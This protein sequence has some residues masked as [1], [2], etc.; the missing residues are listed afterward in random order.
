MFI[1]SSSVTTLFKVTNHWRKHRRVHKSVVGIVYCQTHDTI[2]VSKRDTL[3]TTVLTQFEEYVCVSC[4]TPDQ[5]MQFVQNCCHAV[6]TVDSY[7]H[8]LC[9]NRNPWQTA[10]GINAGVWEIFLLFLF[11][12]RYVHK[13]TKRKKKWLCCTHIVTN[14]CLN[15]GAKKEERIKNLI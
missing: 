7:I 1:Q 10:S 3:H 12:L 15:M 4:D 5:H 2:C 6:C 11:F 14:K 9:P 8:Q 13:T